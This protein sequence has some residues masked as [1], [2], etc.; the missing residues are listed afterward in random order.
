VFVIVAWKIFFDSDL[1]AVDSVHMRVCLRSVFVPDV[2]YL[3]RTISHRHQT[4]R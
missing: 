1:R 3:N 4:E 2:T